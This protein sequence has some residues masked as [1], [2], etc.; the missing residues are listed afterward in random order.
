ME[1]AVLKKR[2]DDIFDSARYAKALE[3]IRKLS[4]DYKSKVKDYK[5]DLSALSAHKHAAKDFKLD[6]GRV[7]DQMEQLEERVEAGKK[8]LKHVEQESERCKDMLIQMEEAKGEID[9][10]QNELLTE[11][12][13][14]ESQRAMLEEDMTKKHSVGELEDMLR[15]FDDQRSTIGDEK[16]RVERRCQALRNDIQL[17]RDEQ[18]RIN[19]HVGKLQAAKE[20]HEHNLKQRLT[21]M[22]Q[23]ARKYGIDLQVTPTQP[24]NTSFASITHNDTSFLSQAGATQDT[25]LTLSEDDMDSF[26]RAL[27]DKEKELKHNLS[28]HRDMTQSQ[29]DQL[30]RILSELMGKKTSI[31]SGTSCSV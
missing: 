4:N 23:M 18:L 9:L 1:G 14:V 31:E 5:A 28:S 6:L 24:Q 3:T 29:E 20:T 19:S 15:D 13:V 27:D 7:A 21:L 16:L 26:Y 11:K 22:E 30:Q 25:S 17:L 10:R 12:S 8:E 2:F